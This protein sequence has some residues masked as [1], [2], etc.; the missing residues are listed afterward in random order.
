MK[1][2]K[3]PIVIDAFQWTAGPGQ[4]EDPDWI[5]E[6]MSRGEVQFD[7]PGTPHVRMA[8]HTLEGVMMADQNDYIIKGVEGELYPCKPSIF[9][10]TYEGVK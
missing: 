9:E 7:R 6:A 8:I 5:L 10:K 2:R 1:F 3:K 4:K